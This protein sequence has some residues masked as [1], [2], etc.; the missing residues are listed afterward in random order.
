MRNFSI[1]LVVTLCLFASQLVAQET[2]ETKA[3]TIA[4]KIEKITDEEQTTLK[5]EVEEVNN[6]LEK[7]VI[8]LEQ[9]DEKKKKLAEARAIIIENRIAIVQEELKE[10]VQAKVDGKIGATGKEFKIIFRKSKKNKNIDYEK[11]T[12]SQFVFAMGANNLVTEGKV[13]GSD[14][15]YLDSNFYEWGL[16]YNSRLVKT[17]NLLHAKYGLSLMYNE[18]RP[19]DNRNFVMNG[20]QTDLI[21]NPIRLEESRF[22]NVYLVAPI[23]LEF[24]FSKKT[25]SSDTNYFR[26]H[27]SFRFGIGGYTGIRLKSKQILEYEENNLNATLKTKGD[28]NTTDFIYGLSTYIGYKAISLYLKYDLNPLFRNN[29]TKQNNVSLGVRFDLN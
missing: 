23:H 15:K 12:T 9:A 8:T 10:L 13:A 24:D 18:L 20:N 6:Q 17:D 2:F 4:E 22:R 5:N 27:Q 28:F 1:Y 7:K 29:T 14:F 3:K 16:T 11:R 19:T 21:V 25:V 26:T